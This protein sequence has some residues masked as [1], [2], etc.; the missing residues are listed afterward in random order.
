MKIKCPKCQSNKVSITGS[1]QFPIREKDKGLKNIVI[2]NRTLSRSENLANKI[3]GEILP[4]DRFTEHLH[5]FDIIISA[6]SFEGYLITSEHIK[7][8][9][10]RRKGIPTVMM[11]IAIPRILIAKSTFN[12]SAISL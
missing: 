12:D 10:K 4:F 2:T 8:M 6:T 11:D 1:G 3:D 5:E 7:E 9:Q